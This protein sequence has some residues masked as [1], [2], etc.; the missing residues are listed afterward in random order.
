MGEAN[1]SSKLSLTNGVNLMIMAQ[2]ICYNLLLVLIFMQPSKQTY[3]SSIAV[4]LKLTVCSWINLIRRIS[5]IM[6]FTTIYSF[7]WLV[8]PI[9]ESAS[10]FDG[11]RNI[12]GCFHIPWCNDDRNFA[13]HLHSNIWWHRS[14][15]IL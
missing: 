15:E 10:I 9:A 1:L 2:V 13:T 6:Y 8:I 12:F 11:I 7:Y 14:Y 3:L 5:G 4:S